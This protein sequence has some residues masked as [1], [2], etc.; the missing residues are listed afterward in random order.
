MNKNEQNELNNI[1]CLHCEQTKVK[2]NV[3]LKLQYSIVGHQGAEKHQNKSTDAAATVC[4][5]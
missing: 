5:T 4:V 1:T 2:K 3:F